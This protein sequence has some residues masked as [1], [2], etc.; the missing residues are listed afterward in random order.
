[1]DS[2]SDLIHKCLSCNEICYEVEADFSDEE[3]KH[4]VYALYECP[5]CGFSWEVIACGERFV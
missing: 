3:K 2:M 1:M 5:N 4:K